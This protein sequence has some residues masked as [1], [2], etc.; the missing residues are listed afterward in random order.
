MHAALDRVTVIGDALPL[1][2]I[3]NPTAA[4]VD[5]HHARFVSALVAL[6]DRY[7]GQYAADPN[8]V[9]YCH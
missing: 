4:E 1:P 2:K 3:A 5:E 6:F 9:L 8:A 7:K